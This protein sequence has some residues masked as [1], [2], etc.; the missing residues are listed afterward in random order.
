[1]SLLTNL[2]TS[3]WKEVR[4]DTANWSKWTSWSSSVM[5]NLLYDKEVTLYVIFAS[6]ALTTVVLLSKLICTQVSVD[7]NPYF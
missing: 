5:L 7:T 4:L 6:V 3:S 1:L 2:S